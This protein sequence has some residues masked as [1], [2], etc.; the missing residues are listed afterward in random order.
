MNKEEL[1]LYSRHIML[2]EIDMEGQI[3]LLNSKVAIIGL[4]GLGSP[5]SI[6]LAASG[7]GS[8]SLIDDDLI[9][10]SNLQRQIIY[11]LDDIGKKKSSVAKK[12]LNTLNQN[13]KYI[14]H[15]ERIS[16]KNIDKLLQDSDFIVDCSD[17][18][19]T[20]KLINKYCSVNKK[21]L[22][23]GSCI[24]WKGQILNFNLSSEKSACY[25]CFFESVDGEDLSCRE[26]SI[27]SPLAGVIGSYLSIEIIKSI[28]GLS[29]KEEFLLQID[30]QE[31]K[32]KKTKVLK[33]PLC[34]I[35]SNTKK[36]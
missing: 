10:L 34:K 4:G 23:A 2:P 6:Y 17:N 28:L 29:S 3:M 12:R 18:F 19:E 16:S 33:N 21:N 25:E 11:S 35:C 20:R 36:S 31:N 8:L 15:D 27:L 30:S 9:E 24:G 32:F 22:I 7:I 5:C 14:N 13:I 26:T 1:I